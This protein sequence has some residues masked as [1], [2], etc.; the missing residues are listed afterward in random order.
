MTRR[1]FN[2][3]TEALSPAQREALLAEVRDTLERLPPWEEIELIYRDK[4]ISLNMLQSIYGAMSA[5]F[6]SPEMERLEHLLAGVPEDVRQGIL[7]AAVELAL[8]DGAV[9]R[10]MGARRGGRATKKRQ[11]I[12]DLVDQLVREDPVAKS[13][14]LWRQVPE[15]DADEDPEV[16]RE[17]EK[18]FELEIDPTTAEVVRQRSITRRTFE[19]YVRDAKTR[20]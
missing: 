8:S 1:R 7:H 3:D 12:Q 16:Y 5:V 19:R 15:W 13:R 10:R 18:I 2:M 14:D 11:R 17:G 20:Q 4:G 9:K 6:T